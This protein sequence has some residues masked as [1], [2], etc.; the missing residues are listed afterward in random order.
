MNVP[1]VASGCLSLLAAAVHGVGGEVLV[2]RKLSPAALPASRFGGPRMTMAMLHASW[3]LATVGFLAV[4]CALVLSGW[5]LD[6]ASA[7]ALARVAAAA[8]TGFAAVVLG[9]GW[10]NTSPRAFFEHPGPAVLTVTA[11]L[12]WW[13]A[14]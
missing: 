13:G 7:R 11:A 8:S 6:G 3:H 4:G 1:L 9:I 12:A 5:V 10:A 14:A 2:V